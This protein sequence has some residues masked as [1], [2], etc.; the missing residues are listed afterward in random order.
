MIYYRKD[1]I[2]LP[3]VVD[4]LGVD[5]FADFTPSCAIGWM[6]CLELRHLPCQ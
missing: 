6:L 4:C 1:G 5:H 2:L 3:P